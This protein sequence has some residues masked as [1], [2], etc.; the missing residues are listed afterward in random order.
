MK[1]TSFSRKFSLKPSSAKVEWNDDKRA[2]NNLAESAKIFLSR[3]DKVLQKKIF[4]TKFFSENF[5]RTPRIK[6]SHTNW[7]FFNSL[8]FAPSLEAMKKTSFSRKFSL[9]PSSAK[10]EW[11]F[12][13]RAENNLAESPKIFLSRSDKVL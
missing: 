10:V 2:E 5:I 4:D 13:N 8:L 7:C 3:S 12:D 9:K 1:K 6:F 11:N